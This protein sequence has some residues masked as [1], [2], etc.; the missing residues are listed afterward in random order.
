MELASY[1]IGLLPAVITG[2]VLFYL[3]RAQKKRDAKTERR[4]QVRQEEM[5]VLLDL[6]LATAKLCYATAMAYKRG[7]PNGEMEE[8]FEAY[9]KAI[10]EFKRFERREIAKL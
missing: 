3:Q 4:V 7:Q 9:D 2:G 6:V 5:I 1:L 10:D 8:G